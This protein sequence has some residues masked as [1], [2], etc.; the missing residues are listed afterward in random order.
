MITWFASQSRTTSVATKAPSIVPVRKDF[1][2][3][4]DKYDYNAGSR[5]AE[6]LAAVDLRDRGGPRLAQAMTRD[7][8]PT[9]S[10]RVQGWLAGTRSRQ[11]SHPP[12]SKG[13]WTA[14]SMV[15]LR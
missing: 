7:I 2:G 1:E 5:Q 4:L 8:A 9:G 3:L 15:K 6:C 13:R 12:C 10:V 14:A 11:P